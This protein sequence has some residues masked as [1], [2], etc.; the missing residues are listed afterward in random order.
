MEEGRVRWAQSGD[1]NIA[2]RVLGDG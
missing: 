1:V 2:Y